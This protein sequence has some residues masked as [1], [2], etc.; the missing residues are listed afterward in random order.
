MVIKMY[1]N[2]VKCDERMLSE[3]HQT[4]QRGTR[5]GPG[6]GQKEDEGIARLRV[7]YYYQLTTVTASRTES[8]SCLHRRRGHMNN[9]SSDSL[10]IISVD[11]SQSDVPPT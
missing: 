3:I 11:K 10:P 2:D 8:L 7:T 6:E 1:V 9:V 4:C 5:Q